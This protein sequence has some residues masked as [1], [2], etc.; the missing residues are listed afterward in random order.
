MN[1][2]ASSAR[3]STTTSASTVVTVTPNPAIDHTAWVPG[4]VPGAVNRVAKD[5][6]VPGGKGVNV[7]AGC[8]AGRAHRGHRLPRVEN[9]GTFE[10]FLAARDIA[11]HSCRRRLTRPW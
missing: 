1:D 3:P 9:A 10:A 5:H 2:G 4:F 11:D 6:L 8:P 7:A